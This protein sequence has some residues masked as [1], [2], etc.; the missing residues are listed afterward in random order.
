MNFSNNSFFVSCLAV[1]F[2]LVGCASQEGAD[3]ATFGFG[4]KVD[5]AEIAAWDIDI[6]PD[7]SGLPAGQGTVAEGEILYQQQCLACHGE[8]GRNGINDQLVSKFDPAVNFSLGLE[9]KT[10]GSYWPYATTLY[11]Y[12][13]RAMPHTAPGSLEP[14]EVYALSAYLLVLND[15]VEEDAVM[16][17]DTLPAIEMPARQLFYWSEELP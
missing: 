7:G 8:A 11:D 9:R 1:S 6:K 3:S 14:A 17:R 12:I 15:I 13:H 2:L 16:N 5:R 4:R 10:I